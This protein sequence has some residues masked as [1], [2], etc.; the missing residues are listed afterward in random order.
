MTFLGGGIFMDHAP[1]THFLE[2]RIEGYR[3]SVACG[4][5]QRRRG[6]QMLWE[7]QSRRENEDKI[8]RTGKRRDP[9]DCYFTCP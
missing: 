5:V 2:S 3:R 1:G 7:S 9:Y 6:K 4:L 8:T